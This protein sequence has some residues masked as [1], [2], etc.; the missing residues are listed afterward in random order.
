[1]ALRIRF[2]KCYNLGEL[3]F[4]STFSLWRSYQYKG[5]KFCYHLLS[6][7]G[8]SQA[9]RFHRLKDYSFSRN[10]STFSSLLALQMTLIIFLSRTLKIHR[11]KDRSEDELK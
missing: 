9:I 8:Q 6:N 2:L 1:M 7:P 10:K 11:S 5:R 3:F 4:L